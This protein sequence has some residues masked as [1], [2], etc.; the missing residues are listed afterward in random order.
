MSV[1]SLAWG[2]ATKGKVF[3]M[4]YTHKA[5]IL[6]SIFQLLKATC[7]IDISYFPFDTQTCQLKF[8]AWSYSKSFVRLVTSKEDKV[9]ISESD[10]SPN[11]M[12]TLVDSYASEAALDASVTYTL[13]LERRPLYYVINV[14]LPIIMLS[15]VSIFVFLLPVKSG[16][17]ASFAM[18]VFLSMAVFLTIVTSELPKNS[19]TASLLGIYLITMI[20][21]ST[22]ITILSVFE[23]RL[24]ARDEWRDVPK[25]GTGYRF[26]V[27][28]AGLCRCRRGAV[29]KLG[30]SKVAAAE[31]TEKSSTPDL[32]DENTTDGRDLSWCDV[33]D[34]I[35]FLFFWVCT[36]VTV[37]STLVFLLLSMYNPQ[38]VDNAYSENRFGM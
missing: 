16:E 34:A 29:R 4:F 18:T 15:V 27:S 26:I 35:D 11:P 22:F 25:V 20:S 30:G 13:I 33:A 32:K 24:V 2:L 14:I 1:N 28:V 10:F 36:V 31:M 23:I 3:S 8:T 6:F 5:I 12:W 38:R 9:I 21:L 17:R 7:D 37:V 19:S